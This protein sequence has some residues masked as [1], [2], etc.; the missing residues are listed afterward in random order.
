MIGDHG[1]TARG[2]ARRR[3]IVPA[4]GHLAVLGLLAAGLILAA[5]TSAASSAPPG[6]PASSGV[7]AP[8]V[9][10]V[11]PSIASAE[12]AAA[13]VAATNPRFEGIGQK[14]PDMIGQGSFWEAKPME[15][16]AYTPA[17]PGTWK[18]TYTIGW[19]DCP[20]GCINQHVWTYQVDAD[21]TVTLLSETGDPLGSGAAS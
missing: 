12:A 19:G 11:Q 14:N 4:Q 10:P 2:Q 7:P 16:G 21:G 1:S 20:A 13:A 17:S 6:A 5:C 8:S 9:A 3:G 18:V 15:A